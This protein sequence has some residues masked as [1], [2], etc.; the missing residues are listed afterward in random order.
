MYT[1]RS[2]DIRIPSLCREE[3]NSLIRSSLFN[4]RNVKSFVYDPTAKRYRLRRQTYESLCSMSLLS[5]HI[6]L[7]LLVAASLP[8]SPSRPSS[9]V[10]HL[11]SGLYF[12]SSRRGPSSG[13]W[14]GIQKRSDSDSKVGECFI[15]VAG[16]YYD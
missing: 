7:G 3:S 14:H 12:H 11:L 16:S 5:Y 1:F 9:E 8:P 6:S 4:R 13:Y 2:I 10:L 15:G